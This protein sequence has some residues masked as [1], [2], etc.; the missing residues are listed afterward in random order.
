MTDAG[1]DA[2]LE[3]ILS[4]SGNA[5][6]EIDR[7]RAARNVT[8]YVVRSFDGSALVFSLPLLVLRPLPAEIPLDPR[9]STGAVACIIERIKEEAA[10]DEA[11]GPL[12]GRGCRFPHQ[13]A[14]LTEPYTVVSSPA[15]L[16]S[17][18]WHAGGRNVADGRGI[19]LLV[20]GAVPCPA[21]FSH[22]DVRE[23]AG[24]VARFCEAVAEVTFSVPAR[25]LE[26]AWMAALDQQLLR[27][28]L[29]E[30]G[31]VSF[32]GDG[33]HLARSYTRYRCYFRTAGPKTG[34]SIPFTCPADLSPVELEL[35]ASN[36]T[37]TGLGI[38]KKEVFAVAGSNAEGKTTFLEGIIAGMDDHAPGDGRE[39][40]VT[41][42]DLC[43]AEATNAILTGADVSMFFS[44]LPPGISGTV[45]AASGMGSGSMTMAYQVQRAVGRGCPL[46]IIDEDRAAPNLL[47]GSA[48]QKEDIT[49]LS[50]ILC[51]DRGRMKETALVFAACA[52][53]TLVAQADRIMVLDRH[54]ARAIDREEFR[55]RVA[56]SLE[57]M[58]RDL[59]MKGPAGRGI[60]QPPREGRRINKPS[61]DGAEDHG[62]GIL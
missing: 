37:V 16:A 24:T 62:L 34:T 14:A 43:M 11:L 40:V 31:L 9:G 33:A 45:H 5:R 32:V 42:H 38:R 61:G 15:A 46:L 52:M 17:H 2:C 3:G 53:D 47:V 20:G 30:K 18:L 4:L 51:H 19:R 13:F 49:P 26:A 55:E 7:A 50:A 60:E 59:M 22:R 27:E 57:R 39:M 58:A 10:S 12:V 25:E 54:V 29:P 56:L 36:R 1:P 35:P 21:A 8:A 48:L 44:S 41:V 23:V 6:W 28:M